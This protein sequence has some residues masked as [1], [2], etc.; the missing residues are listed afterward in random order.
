MFSDGSIILKEWERIGFLEE[1]IWG[2]CMGSRSVDQLEKN[3][4]D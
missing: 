3:R 2:V 4:V 1:Y